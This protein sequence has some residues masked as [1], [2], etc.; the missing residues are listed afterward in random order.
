MKTIIIIIFLSSVSFSQ[1][2]ES[3]SCGASYEILPSIIGGMDSLWS[4]LKW[5]ASAEQFDVEGTVYVLAYLDTLGSLDSTK[6]LKGLG[7]GFDEEAL[8]AVKQ[9]K[10][11]PGYVR[12]TNK[13]YNTQER[14]F[15][16]NKPVYSQVVIPVHFKLK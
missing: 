6:I 14:I 9:C 10:F 7:Y 8:N 16:R 15:I 3:T 11:T 4:H 2:V 5:P 1:G 12:V 13:S